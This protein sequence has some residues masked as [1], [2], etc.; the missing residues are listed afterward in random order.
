MTK[1]A[2]IAPASA[3]PLN[4]LNKGLDWL[5]QQNLLF[6]LPQDLLK[7]KLFFASSLENQ[8]EHIQHALASDADY[9]WCLRGGYGSARLL[10]FLDKMKKPKKKKILLG[11]SD[12]TALHLFFNQKWKWN[13]IHSRVLSQMDAQAPHADNNQYE[14]FFKNKL[15]SVHYKGLLPLN[16]S[17]KKKSLITGSVTG[18]NLRILETSLGTSWQLKADHKILF[19]EDVGERGYALHRMLTHLKQANV[20]NKKVKAVI[21]G[22]FTEGLEKDGSDRTQEALKAFAL[23]SPIPFY[24]GMPCGH[25][26]E[27]YLLPFGTKAVLTTG[28]K[29]H[30]KVEV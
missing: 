4:K 18:G 23:E 7:P 12:I 28:A 8:L 15:E 24:S 25:G 27:N 10:P 13:S 19:L 21:L 9:L 2:I 6:H 20:L 30:L 5:D 22:S 14:K 17:A 26:A 11:F 3:A 29:A 1:I 16:A